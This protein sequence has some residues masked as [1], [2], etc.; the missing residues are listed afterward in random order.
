[1]CLI[2]RKLHLKSERGHCSEKELTAHKLEQF[3]IQ[4]FLKASTSVNLWHDF[5]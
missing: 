2:A 3:K 1:M 4:K 5:N